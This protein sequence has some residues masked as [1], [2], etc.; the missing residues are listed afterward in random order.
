MIC[1]LSNKYQSNSSKI[2]PQ[3][4]E[5]YKNVGWT[6]VSMSEILDNMLENASQNTAS[7]KGTR[8]CIP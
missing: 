6:R 1:A 8:I 5:R 4:L 7:L 3:T 2:G